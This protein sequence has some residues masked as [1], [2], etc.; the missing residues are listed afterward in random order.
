[1]SLRSRLRAIPVDRFLLLLIAT[2]VIAAVLPARGQVADAFDWITYGAI[3]LLFFLYGARLS[4][5]AVWA[6]LLHW[7]LQGWSSCRPSRC[8]RSSGSS[9]I[10]WPARS[11]RPN[12]RSG[13]SI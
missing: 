7:R 10:P 9:S 8:F 5:Q 11:C 1:M 12:W 2:V 3:A 6:G 13:S 4:P